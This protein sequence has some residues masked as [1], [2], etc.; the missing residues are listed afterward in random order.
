VDRVIVVA[1]HQ[2]IMDGPRDEV[3]MKLKQSPVA[4]ESAA[5]IVKVVK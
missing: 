3:L 5:R 4:G 1:K 2:V